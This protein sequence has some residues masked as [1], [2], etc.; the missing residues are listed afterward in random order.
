MGPPD[1][2]R[3]NHPKLIWKE[4]RVVAGVPL[5]AVQVVALVAGALSIL[6][7]PVGGALSG[8]ISTPTS[9][10]WFPQPIVALSGNAS[11]PTLDS[12]VLDSSEGLRG[13]FNGTALV[14]STEIHLVEG[15]LTNWRFH[16]Q[17]NY[18]PGTNGSEIGSAFHATRKQLGYE[19]WVVTNATA[20]LL[21][22]A[23]SMAARHKPE[24]GATHLYFDSTFPNPFVIG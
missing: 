9:G 23:P 5:H 6:A 14:N 13:E 3:T 15:K 12:M 11:G 8:G 17:F 4:F 10:E 22:G 24:F 16:E 20:S 18:Q 7:A 19:G 2:R 21:N 1:V